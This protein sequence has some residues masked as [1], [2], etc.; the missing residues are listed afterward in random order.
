MRECDLLLTIGLV[1]LWAV[2]IQS[3]CTLTPTQV[4]YQWLH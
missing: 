4:V 2:P 1:L 3:E